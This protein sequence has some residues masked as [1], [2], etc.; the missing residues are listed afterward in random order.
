NTSFSEYNY[1]SNN[2]LI[3]TNKCYSLVFDINEVPITGI[4]SSGVKAINLKED[5]VT[6]GTIF[7]D[8]YE[9]I[10]IVTNKGTAKR[11]KISDVEK[12]NRARRGVLIL[13]EVKTNPHRL[14]R[15]LIINTKE[16]FG[17]K[18]N[19]SLLTF[20]NSELP[21]M[22]RYST[23]SNIAKNIEEVFEI[24]VLKTVEEPEKEVSLE[25]VDQKMMTISDFLKNF[26]EE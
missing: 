12:T 17:V 10:T 21:I 4:K 23:G 16:T 13:R 9:Y 22:D 1:L 2:V 7:D 8:S 5:Y 6:N 24:K 26:N 18:T 11:V 14:V 3:T 15:S 19:D 25:D 20:K